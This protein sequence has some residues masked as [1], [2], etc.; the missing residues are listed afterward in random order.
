MPTLTNP[1]RGSSYSAPRYSPPKVSI[2]GGQDDQ[3]VG[4]FEFGLEQKPGEII[5]AA[6]ALTEAVVGFTAGV[7][8]SIPIFGKARTSLR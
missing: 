6:G 2:G 1:N 5:S 3:T 8:R 7:A 4:K